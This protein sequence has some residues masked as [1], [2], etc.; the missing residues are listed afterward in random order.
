MENTIACQLS[1]PWS[2]I[3]RPRSCIRPCQ[4]QLSEFSYCKLH[5]GWVWI[6]IHRFSL[7]FFYLLRSQ[8]THNA[9]RRLEN[10]WRRTL[11]KKKTALIDLETVSNRCVAW[12]VSVSILGREKTIFTWV[13]NL[14]THWVHWLHGYQKMK[15]VTFWLRQKFETGKSVATLQYIAHERLTDIFDLLKQ[16]R[17]FNTRRILSIFYLRR[18]YIGGEK[19]SYNKF[20]SSRV[21]TEQWIVSNTWV[22]KFELFDKGNLVI[23]KI[24]P[25]NHAVC[26]SSLISSLLTLISKRFIMHR[27]SVTLTFEPF[28]FKCHNFWVCFNTLGYWRLKRETVG[29]S[30]LPRFTCGQI[31]SKNY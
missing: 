21:N 4:F 7:L 20:F 22:L 25:T 28:S 5:L 12:E 18:V 30:L 10:L 27:Q 17:E 3:L 14:K 19:R 1:R 29:K 15:S 26:L 6:S 31:P 13:L 9:L 23:S 24:P 11:A 2:Y 16:P 8:V